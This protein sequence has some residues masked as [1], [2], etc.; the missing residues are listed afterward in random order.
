MGLE[1]RSTGAGGSHVP[2][3]ASSIGETLKLVAA[4]GLRS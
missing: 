4:G 3:V 1:D 2:Q